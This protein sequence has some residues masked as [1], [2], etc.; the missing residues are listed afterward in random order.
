MNHHRQKVIQRHATTNPHGI[1]VGQ[2]W[3]DNDK[4]MNG[5]QI[6]VISIEGAYAF[7]RHPQGI[8]RP[9]RIRLDRFRPT[10]TGFVLIS[11]QP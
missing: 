3:Q 5:R 7:C 10:S 1:K 8:G 11:E 2:I 4:R 6:K 9:V